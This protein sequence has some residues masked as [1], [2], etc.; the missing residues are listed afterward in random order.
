MESVNV[1]YKYEKE[2]A[3]EEQAKEVAE[4]FHE[5]LKGNPDY[6]ETR[7]LLNVEGSRVL[8]A[9]FSDSKTHLHVEEGDDGPI[10]ELFKVG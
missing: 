5:V 10:L 8:L 4:Y 9:E 6:R 1:N 2:F 7:I 3:S